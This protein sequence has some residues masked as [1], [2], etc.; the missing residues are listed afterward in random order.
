M[1][2]TE[3]T[4]GGDADVWGGELNSDLDLIDQHDHTAGKGVK[5]P[6]A[7]LNINADVS[8]SS[9]GTNYAIKDLKALD[10]APVA[11]ATVSTLADAFFV[12]ISDN[13][14]YWRNHSGTNVK[15][16]SGSSL[17]VSGFV[18]G[19]GGDYSSVSA[20]LSYDDSTRRYLFQQEL[21]AGLR[22]WAGI[23]SADLDI[24]EKAVSI[25]N[26]VT[27][28]SPGALAASYTLTFPAALPASTY[29]ATI[30]NAGLIGTP[31]NIATPGTVTGTDFRFTSN[32]TTYLVTVGS[33]DEFG[34]HIFNKTPN[35]FSFQASA[36]PIVFPLNFPAGCVVKG[37][38]AYVNK[39]SDGTK[40]LHCRLYKEDFTTGAETALES[41][42]TLS[43]NNPGITSFG[44][45][46]STTMAT[47]VAYYI[48]VTPGGT[49][50]DQLYGIGIDITRP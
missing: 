35:S 19:I 1:G 18:G 47:G 21:A 8:W 2:L 16:T 6:S 46:M 33:M 34:S 5:V 24:Y 26:K 9:G 49:A 50:V 14:L 40:T 45:A 3:P 30:S 23:A 12:N 38:L 15:V 37:V 39:T 13:E 42:F 41:D 10:M 11:S 20:L 29:I 28:K 7:G 48:K 25:T 4:V 32:Q 22:A 17:N 27:L 36:N 44:G 43:T 31:T